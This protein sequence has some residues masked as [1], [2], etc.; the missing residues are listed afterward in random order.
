M[1]QDLIIEAAKNPEPKPEP[2]KQPTKTTPKQHAAPQAPTTPGTHAIK[3]TANY[4]PSPEIDDAHW[5][6]YYEQEA[7]PPN[8]EEF[9]SGHNTRRAPQDNQQWRSSQSRVLLTPAQK[10][11]ALLVANTGLASLEPEHENWLNEQDEYLIMLGRLLKVL[12]ERPHYNLSH[13]I[14]YWRGLYGNDDTEKLAKIAGSDLLHAAQAL[15]IA[16][17]DKP[18]KVDY[19]ANSA[20]KDCIAKLYDAKQKQQ[21]AETQA[22]AHTN[23]FEQLTPEQK[24]QIRNSLIRKSSPKDI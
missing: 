1:L 16:R 7:P 9:Y 4:A 19:D 22:I 20:F 8:Y 17:E 23:N 10:A 15:T 2:E 5:A 3:P 18:A 6:D 13:L 14:G 12:H 11:V 24:A 21:T